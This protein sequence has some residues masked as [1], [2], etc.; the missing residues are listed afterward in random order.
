[1][2]KVQKKLRLLDLEFVEDDLENSN[3]SKSSGRV[4]MDV[5]IYI[6]ELED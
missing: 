3:N 4:S 2:G 1:M 6:K 5:D